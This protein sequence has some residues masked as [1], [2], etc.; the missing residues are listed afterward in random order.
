M[1]ERNTFNL[2][3]YIRS[4]RVDNK[5]LVPIYMRIT[6]NGVDSSI[7]INR[8]ISE[9]LWDIKRGGPKPR[10]VESDEINTYLESLRR[11]VFEAHRQLIEEGKV[12]TPDAV[13]SIVLG[14]KERNYSLI[15][16]MERHN[17]NMEAGLGI[18]SS[19]GNYK[20]FKTSLKYLKEF[21]KMHTGNTDV[22]LTEIDNNF[23]DS[24]IL[25]LQKEKNC[26]HNGAMKQLQRLKKVFNLGV[27]YGW[28]SKTPFSNYK[29]KFKPYDKIIL[30]AEEL[31]KIENLKGLNPKLEITRDAFIFSCYTGLAYVDLRKLSRDN[32]IIGVDGNPWVITRRQK[33]EIKARIPLL[34]KA[35]ALIEKYKNHMKL[36]D[37]QVIPIYSNQKT[38]D[39][40]KEIASKAEISKQ[41]SFHCGRHIFATVI[42]LANGV[43]IE[44]VSKA[45][46]HTDIRTTQV[47][48]RVLDEKIAKDFDLL[49]SKL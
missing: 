15:K 40:L 34:P 28:I 3:F 12:V 22:L 19:L 16:L 5:G 31:E 27:N 9:K 36:K 44:T 21:V 26:F 49:K 7:S 6:V 17:K 45:L 38:N 14:L 18:T 32:I 30:T 42:T 48:A 4:N 46:G 8:K 1:K 47:Y 43:P 10:M 11:R 2:L 35:L 20:N 39:Y 33:T 13:L 37:G 24:Y 23:I 25:Y 41:L 29:I